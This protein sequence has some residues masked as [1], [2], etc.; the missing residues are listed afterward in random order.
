MISD[1]LSLKLLTNIVK[2]VIHRGD[3]SLEKCSDEVADTALF[4][5]HKTLYKYEILQ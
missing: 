2:L 1:W 3:L 5:S 4:E